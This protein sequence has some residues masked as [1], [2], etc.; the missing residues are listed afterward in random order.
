MASE[1]SVQRDIWL[2][3]QQFGA[4]LF[5]LNEGRAWLSNLGPKGVTR[6][7]DGAM[8]IRAPRSIALG[9]A[10]VKGDPVKGACDLP[11]WTTVQ[12]T[13]DMVGRK[14]AVF[15]SLEIKRSKGGRASPEQ[16]SWQRTVEAAGGIAGIVNSPEEASKIIMHWKCQQ[17]LDLR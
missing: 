14:V 6:L 16:L 11:G 17:A 9:F 12:I 15:T 4:R 10:D 3:V 5:R 1:S 2:Y 8:L 13:P 7:P